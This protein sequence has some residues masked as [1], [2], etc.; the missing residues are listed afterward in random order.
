[1]GFA[2]NRPRRCG[3]SSVFDSSGNASVG[4]YAAQHRSR[5]LEPRVVIPQDLVA[6][7][8]IDEYNAPAT[9]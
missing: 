9:A 6:S 2:S 5:L 8:I 7:A 4:Y 1:M 3:R